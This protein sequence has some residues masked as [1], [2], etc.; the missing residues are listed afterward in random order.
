MSDLVYGGISA[1]SLGIHISGEG[2]YSSPERDR[3]MISVDGRNGDLIIDNGRYENIRVVYPAFMRDG[4]R[5]RESEIRNRFMNGSRGYRR[6][7]DTYHPNEFRLAIFDGAFQPET[8]PWNASAHFDLV[9]NCKPQ[10]F[11]VA[12]EETRTF[13]TAG[14]LNNPSQE[15]A[16]P[17]IRVYGFGT[18]TVG[19]TVV[20][21]TQHG[22]Q[23]MD[24]DCELGDA[25]CGS[26]NLNAYVTKSFPTLGAGETG[27][28]FSGNITRVDITPHWWRV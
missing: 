8:G 19:D 17:L 7:T 25:Y 4:F 15:T 3:E 22:Q 5:L 13:R 10:R 11:L 26:I 12:G 1:A 27:L 9:F 18:L 2:T 21:I 20:T 23:Y 14:T 16:L 28:A 24:I 6:L